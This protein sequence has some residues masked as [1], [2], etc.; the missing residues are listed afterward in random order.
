MLKGRRSRRCGG[1]IV[2]LV[3]GCWQEEELERRERDRLLRVFVERI[4]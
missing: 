1:G 4:L 2:Y 3:V